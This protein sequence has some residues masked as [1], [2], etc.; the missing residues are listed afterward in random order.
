M[1]GPAVALV[2]VGLVAVLFAPT[3][4]WLARTWQVHPYYGH[5]WLVPVVAAAFAWRARA[6]FTAGGP[7]DAGFALVAAGVALHLAAGRWQAFPVSACALVVVLAGLAW[8]F[9]GRPALQAAA[10]PAGL[11]LLAI[12]WPFVERTAPFLA[13][14]VARAAAATAGGLGAAVVQ[15]GAE[16][17]V[18]DGAFTVGA[19]CSGLQSA[20]ALVTLAMVLAGVLDGPWRRRLALVLLALPIALAANWLRLTG[21]LWMAAAHGSAEGMAWFHGPPALLLYAMAAAGLVAAGR[22]MGCDVRGAA[23]GDA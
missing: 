2:L 6:R 13:A 10:L 5:G 1:G 22:W 12:P 23:Y 15:R 3:V 8:T 20:V 19:P 14:W 4:A 21:L 16:L 17:A 9:G 11:L 18:A 7:A